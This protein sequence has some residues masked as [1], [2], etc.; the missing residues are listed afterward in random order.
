MQ[1]A[2]SRY[3][4]DVVNLFYPKVCLACSEALLGNE[5]V[6]CF[7]CEATLPETGHWN[8]PENALMKRFWGRVDLQG[9]AAMLQFQK[10]GPVQHL[11]HQLKYRGRQDV[12]AFLGQNFGNILKNDSS[13][14]KDIDVVVP[15]PLHWKKL[16][17]RGYN[18][19]SFFAEELAK[20]L[21]TGWSDTA[22]ERVHE[23]ISQTKFSRLDR[24]G[25]VAEIFAVKDAT[26]LAG[27]HVL[28]VDDVVTTGATAEACMQTVLGVEGTRVSFAAMAVALR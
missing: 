2:L 25:N 21:N 22:L 3:M 17:S 12:A 14:I 1:S 27:K 8:D 28:V 5:E 19:C 16:K 26:Q 15:V 20:A 9:A 7:K 11:L 18:Q 6:I 4:L 23:N 10:G 24:W 13:V